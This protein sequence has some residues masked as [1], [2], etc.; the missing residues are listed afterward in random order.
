[1]EN[2]KVKFP[3]V[4]RIPILLSIPHCGTSFPEEIRDEYLPELIDAPDDTDWYVDRLYDFAPTMGITVI[5][6]VWSRWVID[7]NRDPE[8]K[9]LY[10]DGR[11]ITD[12]CPL[13]TF[14]GQS[15]YL[16]GRTQMNHEEIARR[17][18][19]Y[20][21]PYHLALR[22]MLDDLKDEFS[23]VLL[24]DC[25]SIRQSVPTIQE[26]RFPDLILGSSDGK[27]ADQKLIEVALQ[28]LDNGG[29]MLQ[30]NRPFKGGF[31]TRNYGNPQDG[32]HALQLEMSKINYMDDSETSFH[33][34]RAKKMAELLIN[35][36]SSLY[37]LLISLKD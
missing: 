24:W 37:G 14:L 16:D 3:T 31:I 15:I 13:T 35:T 8:N 33:P 34:E 32:Q 1:M 29:Y 27:S 6:A 26:A 9:P 18:K 20:F 10:D 7:L 2:Y 36:L 19:S 21:A 30:H 4:P 12:V 11:I 5:S 23:S 22:K 25:H 17:R 28:N